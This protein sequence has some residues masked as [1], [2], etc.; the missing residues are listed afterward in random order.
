MPIATTWRSTALALLCAAPALAEDAGL[1][2]LPSGREVA[3]HDVIWGEP[4]PTGLTLRFR[5]IEPELERALETMNYDEQESDMAYLCET[6]AL[7]RIAS[8]GPQPSQVVISISDRPV[9][10]GTADPEAVQVFEAYS[11]E[12][13]GCVWEGF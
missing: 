9:E 8:S 2:A 11:P 12:A 10:F 3:F 5:F 4:G 7:D 13:D 1:I 6:Y